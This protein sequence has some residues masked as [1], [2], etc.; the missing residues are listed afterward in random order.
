MLKTLMLAT[1]LIAS[2]AATALPFP[3]TDRFVDD[4]S[5]YV[6]TVHDLGS[7]MRLRGRHPTTG[8][9]FNI[10]VSRSGKVRGTFEG[11]PVAFVMGATSNTEQLATAHKALNAAQ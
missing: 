4:K 2:T 7:K 6:V 5:G 11:K 1:A 10:A 3:V 9:T 8:Q